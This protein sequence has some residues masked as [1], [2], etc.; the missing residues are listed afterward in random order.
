MTRPSLD[1]DETDTYMKY[2]NASAPE[3]L[4]RIYRLKQ[5]LRLP[6]ERRRASLLN[7]SVLPITPSPVTPSPRHPVTPSPHICSIIF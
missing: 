2:L 7:S 4:R 6:T 3:D 1:G 5:D